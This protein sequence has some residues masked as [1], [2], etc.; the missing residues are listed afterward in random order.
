M[1]GNSLVATRREEPVE[2][3]AGLW[4]AEDLELVRQGI[5]NRRWLDI[6][7]GVPATGLDAL[8]FVA[9]PVS[10]AL[11][12][13]V[14]W[15]IEHIRPLRE[16]LDALAG[17]PAQ[18]KAHAQTWRNVASTLRNQ[19][20]ELGA[21]VRRNTGDWEGRGGPYYR[22][23]AQAQ[24]AGIG[25]LAEAADVT[26]IVTEVAGAVVAG[27]RVMVRDMI[28]I[29]VSRLITCA[30]AFIFTAGLATPLIISRVASLVAACAARIARLIRALVSSLRELGVL[31]RRLGEIVEQ[32][33]QWLR[34]RFTGSPPPPP[35]P[36]PAGPRIIPP[37]TRNAAGAPLPEPNTTLGVLLGFHRPD[38]LARRQIVDGMPSHEVQAILDSRQRLRALRGLSYEDLMKAVF[39]PS[40]FSHIKVT[41]YAEPRLV[42]GRMVDGVVDT[43]NH[44]MDVLADLVEMGLLSPDQP[45]YAVFQKAMSRP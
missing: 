13:A 26:A 5:V 28:A 18:I 14:S 7:L 33:R 11:Q 16:A 29:L 24:Q 34:R 12:Y 23:W 8:A 4:L 36:R 40:D 38:V 21:A 17:D 27:V 37:P 20:V 2:A 31:V 10:S 3:W 9:D 39:D 43:G 25:G 19:A 42:G 22:T 44:R 1:I 15:L 45:M 32:I 35:A 30:G 6:T 41:E